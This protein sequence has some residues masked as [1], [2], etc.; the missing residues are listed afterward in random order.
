VKAHLGERVRQS[1]EETLN[2]MLDACPDAEWRLIFALARLGG[3]RVPL[4]ILGLT[5]GDI[6]WAEGRFTV[7]S[8]KTE[9]HPGQES[10]EVPLFP[11]LLPCLSEAFERA[12]PGAEHVITRY[13][14]PNQ[15]LSTQFR[16]ILRRA[17]IEPWPKLYQNLRST[18][19]TELT[20]CFPVHVVCA[21]LGNRA[22]VVMKHCLQ[23]TDERFRQ[24]AQK[25]VQKAVQPPSAATCRN[26]PA[27]PGQRKKPRLSHRGSRWQIQAMTYQRNWWALE[28]S[29]LRPPPCRGG[30]LAN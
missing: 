29:N 24:A 16:R 18:R 30:A 22:P 25:A 23:M 12:E 20:D 4:E 27:E 3:L 28:D 11:E 5:W 17:G 8:P 19:Q 14:L 10:R 13:R 21:W 6:R 26:P 7:H 15:N 2:G 9:H 1:V